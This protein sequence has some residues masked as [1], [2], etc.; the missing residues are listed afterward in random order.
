MTCTVR[1]QIH[2]CISATAGAAL[3]KPLS[4]SLLLASSLLWGSFASGQTLESTIKE[5]KNEHL[6]RLRNAA[7]LVGSAPADLIITTSERTSQVQQEGGDP[8][9]TPSISADGRIVATARRVP[10]A[11]MSGRPPLIVS[12]YFIAER[13]WTEYPELIIRGASVAISPDG[14]R[15]A[16]ADMFAERTLLHILDLKTGKITLLAPAPENPG[17]ITWA[18]DGRRLAFDAEDRIEDSTRPPIS[19]IY[20]WDL[21]TGVF[22]RIAVG[23][24]PS[25]SPS[26]NWIAFSRY[27]WDQDQGK[28][29]WYVRNTNRVS[30]IR[31]DGTDSRL[32]VTYDRDESLNNLQPVWSPDSKTL[33]INRIRDEAGNM[34]VDMVDVASRKVTK[35]FRKTQPVYAWV[36]VK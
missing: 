4:L 17:H 24:S 16:R 9:V 36:E 3:V 13:H 23:A 8:L 19:A 29:D 22:S 1:R 25:W 27:P 30:L 5:K 26:G 28:H 15:L 18:P 21:E 12:T 35:K 33:L 31:P 32:L 10:G 7:L 20:V 11:T 34:N 14:S 2:A 6:P